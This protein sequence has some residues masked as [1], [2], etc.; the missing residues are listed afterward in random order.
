[1]FATVGLFSKT[2]VGLVSALE[3]RRDQLLQ[4]PLGN[5]QVGSDMT[6]LR[7]GDRDTRRDLR[8]WLGSRFVLSHHARSPE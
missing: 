7:A 5:P 8:A 1:M 6:P 4:I 3:D 2:S